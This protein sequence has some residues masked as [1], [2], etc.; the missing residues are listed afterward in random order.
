MSFSLMYSLNWYN[1]KDTNGP[2]PKTKYYEE[3]ISYFKFYFY[4]VYLELSRS[5]S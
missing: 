1:P 3:Q 5:I 2:N 4:F